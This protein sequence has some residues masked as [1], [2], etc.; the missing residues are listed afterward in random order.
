MRT[1]ARAH[2]CCDCT[3]AVGHRHSP[4]GPVVGA[5]AVTLVVGVIALVLVP[6]G[7]DLDAIP[8]GA[9]VPPLTL[10]AIAVLVD[11]HA[12][13]L[14]VSD[15]SCRRGR[16]RGIGRRGVEAEENG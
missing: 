6:L 10:V 13:A 16:P 1:R 12:V 3:A 9:V 8:F 14:S 5:E 2:C 11:V 15:E 4:V 7:E